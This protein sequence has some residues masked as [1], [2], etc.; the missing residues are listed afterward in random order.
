MSNV[1]SE[2]THCLEHGCAVEIA[3]K[4]GR[5]RPAKW[6][7]SHRALKKAQF[8]DNAGSACAE[9]GCDRAVRARGVCSMHY[10]AQLRA[11]GRLT[12]G[13][14]DERRRSN[15]QARRARK[16]DAFI[17][18]VSVE[19]LAERDEFRCGICRADVDM[20]LAYPDP[21]SRSLDHIVPLARGGAHSY[22]NTQLAHLRCNV[23]KG[24]KSPV[25]SAVA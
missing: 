1:K 20:A 9:D 11:E 21:M 22:S 25:S 2:L 17:E 19:V 18:P 15:Y 24:A 10:K 8:R 14:W 4:P 13:P 3:Q 23:S 5:G 16:M 6:C 12:S 7:E